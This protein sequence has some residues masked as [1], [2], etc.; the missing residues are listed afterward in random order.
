MSLSLRMFLR[1][2]QEALSETWLYQYFPPPPDK[3]KYIDDR[4]MS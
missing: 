2:G 3:R 1:T 4:T